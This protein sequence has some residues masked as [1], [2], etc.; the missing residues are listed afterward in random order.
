MVLVSAVPILFPMG[1]IDCSAPS[2]NRP[3]PRMMNAVPTR[4][5]RRRSVS[6]GITHRHITETIAAIGTTDSE[7]S[8]SFSVIAP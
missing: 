6:V 5:L 7:L 2:E 1:V 3:I 4:K 8:L